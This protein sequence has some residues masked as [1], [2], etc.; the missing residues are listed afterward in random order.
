MD[1]SYDTYLSGF[2]SFI[3]YVN[4]NYNKSVFLFL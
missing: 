4:L 2:D 3:I 1:I